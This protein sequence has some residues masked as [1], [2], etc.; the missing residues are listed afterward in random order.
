MKLALG[1]ALFVQG[2][3]RA[4][5][6]VVEDDGAK[7]KFNPF[8]NVS[9]EEIEAL[10]A[11]EMADI[12][13]KTADPAT[14]EGSAARLS[15]DAWALDAMVDLAF[16]KAAAGRMGEADDDFSRLLAYTPDNYE[17]LT[18]RGLIALA[19][20]DRARGLDLLQEALNALPPIAES[21]RIAEAMARY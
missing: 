18:G 12:L 16:C 4:E 17:A 10:I 21:D 1:R 6:P 19:R 3:A 8:A 2:G 13:G 9:R 15:A 14:C 5:I 20:G 11:A 7:L